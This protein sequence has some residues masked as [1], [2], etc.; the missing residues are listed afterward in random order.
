MDALL[1]ITCGGNPVETSYAC[2]EDVATSIDIV[3][4]GKRITATPHT[5]TALTTSIGINVTN[6]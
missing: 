4:D 6:L 2:P 1:T 3:I 5:V